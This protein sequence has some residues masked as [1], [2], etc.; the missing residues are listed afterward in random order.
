[1]SHT[2]WIATELTEFRSP[3]TKGGAQMR[4]AWSRVF[5]AAA[6][7][8]AS[9]LTAACAVDATG[10]GGAPSAP[11][12][13]SEPSAAA[14]TKP[15]DEAL[16]VVSTADQCSEGACCLLPTPPG[17]YPNDPLEDALSALGCTPPAAYRES[18]GDSATW[19]YVQC[20][21]K[22]DLLFVVERYAGAPYDA[23]FSGSSCLLPNVPRDHVIVEF[24]PTC[25]G[26]I[27]IF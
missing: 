9:T 24:D 26:C 6:F 16:H 21:A 11:A 2:E 25:D 8:V 10:T 3:T 4:K 18:A 19:L 7:A 12:G 22:L 5:Q 14:G 20:P 13:S 17:G 23:R 1:M 27:G 15:S